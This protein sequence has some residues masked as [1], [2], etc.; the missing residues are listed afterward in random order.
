[1]IVISAYYQRTFFSVFY[2]VIASVFANIQYKSG[3]SNLKVA[4][5]IFLCLMMFEV[6][7]KY[8]IL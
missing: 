1:M 6:V 2:L 5:L 7:R 3:V 4:W 8:A